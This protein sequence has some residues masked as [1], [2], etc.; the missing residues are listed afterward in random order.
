MISANELRKNYFK[1]EEL[2]DTLNYIEKEILHKAKKGEGLVIV[3][4]PS[5][6]RNS[7]ET[8][9]EEK[10]YGVWNTPIQLQPCRPKIGKEYITICWD[11]ALIYQQNELDNFADMLGRWM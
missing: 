6:Y 7:I 2:E 10:N 9:L 5:D 4:I 1:N 3:Q 8:Y 11:E